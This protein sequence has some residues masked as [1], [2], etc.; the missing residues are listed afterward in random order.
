MAKH[1]TLHQVTRGRT[2]FEPGTVLT[3]LSQDEIEVLKKTRSIRPYFEDTDAQL[4]VLPEPK[5]PKAKAEAEP[6]DDVK[7]SAKAE[8]KSAA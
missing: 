8:T 7:A 4:P 5:A 1:T 2:R 6:K 3:D